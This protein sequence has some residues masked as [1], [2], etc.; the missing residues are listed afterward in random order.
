MSMKTDIWP[1]CGDLGSP[2]GFLVYCDDL[3]HVIDF[4]LGV[5]SSTFAFEAEDK[6][7]INSIHDQL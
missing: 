2:R 3:D 6:W 5:R 4:S 7:Q 1:I